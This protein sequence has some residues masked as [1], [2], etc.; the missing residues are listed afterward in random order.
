MLYKYFDQK[1]G[2]ANIHTGADIISKNQQLANELHKL[3][4]RKFVIEAV[5]FLL[6]VIDNH[7]KYAWI[8]SMKIKRG[9][10]I[11]DAFQKMLDKSGRKPSKIQ[12][13]QGNEF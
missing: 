5:R 2:D 10:A 3:I 11:T 6:R 13:R 9:I 7:S 8:V 1:A 4:F 12:V